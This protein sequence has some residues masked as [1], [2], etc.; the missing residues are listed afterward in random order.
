MDVIPVKS[1][2]SFVLYTWSDKLREIHKC[3]LVIEITCSNHSFPLL[4]D[5]LRESTMEGPQDIGNDEES[6]PG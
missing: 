1:I 6:I 4:V 5:A 3:V 2:S